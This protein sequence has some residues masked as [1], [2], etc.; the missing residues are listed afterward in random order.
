MALN[1][2]PAITPD[3]INGHQ[4]AIYPPM[5][6]LAGMQLDVLTPLK[7]GPMTSEEVAAAV[8]VKPAG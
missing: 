3:I 1:T 7:D 8:G 6:M 4:F 2:T 5:A